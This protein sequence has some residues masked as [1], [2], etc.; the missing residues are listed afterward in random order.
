VRVT[1]ERPA[2]HVELSDAAPSIRAK[3]WRE[4]RQKA[5]DALFATL[6]ARDKPQVFAERVQQISFD[7][8]EKRPSGFAPEPVAP[9]VPVRD[10]QPASP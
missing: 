5:L 4:R 8:M 9:R 1:G 6:R 3:L 7:D 10:A 2:R